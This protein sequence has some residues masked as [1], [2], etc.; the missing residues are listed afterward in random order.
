MNYIPS[1]MV[2]FVP[3]LT[4]ILTSH[5]Y[6]RGG[7]RQHLEIRI[8][9]VSVKS[10][11]AR[12]KGF[13]NGIQRKFGVDCEVL[14]IELPNTGFTI[15]VTENSCLTG[16]YYL[17]VNIDHP[18]IQKL[19]GYNPA[20]YGIELCYYLSFES[21]KKVL[22]KTKTENGLMNSTF[23]FIEV[24]SKT[25][26][27]EPETVESTNPIDY[28]DFEDLLA[29]FCPSAILK[30]EVEPVNQKVLEQKRIIKSKV[31]GDRYY[32]RD[33]EG[34]VIDVI[35]LGR[36][37]IHPSTTYYYWRRDSSIILSYMYSIPNNSCPVGTEGNSESF[38]NQ[39]RKTTDVREITHEVYIRYRPK[40]KGMRSVEDIL[41]SA[42]TD[43]FD[44]LDKS[45]D[46][47][48]EFNEDIVKFLPYT[49]LV[50]YNLLNTRISFKYDQEVSPINQVSDVPL[51]L[52]EKNVVDQIDSD[53][54]LSLLKK[55]SLDLLMN[56]IKSI[57][58][59]EISKIYMTNFKKWIDLDELE[60]NYPSDPKTLAIYEGIAEGFST[61]L[62]TLSKL[63]IRHSKGGTLAKGDQRALNYVKANG[64][65]LKSYT[66][67]EEVITDNEL[68]NINSGLY[69]INKYMI[70]IP[71]LKQLLIDKAEAHKPL[72][73]EW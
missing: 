41:K 34:E 15:Q 18:D 12:L 17:K 62:A 38:E 50:D 36:V 5:S 63:L 28:S 51:Y 11:T 29:D 37:S 42:Y 23:K 26:I 48:D 73:R 25:Q 57:D 4:S 13:K 56:H 16:D 7:T 68:I 30:S 6:L 32:F 60:S 43:V 70:H 45:P 59:E 22:L 67:T 35:Y 2:I 3:S 46:L 49:N 8:E 65:T 14:K 55:Y 21:F 39:I 1:K 58:N 71:R 33:K 24:N 66:T 72:E 52:V 40:Y 61:S 47:I 44:T 20:E 69:L 53:K 9:P 19:L 54:L 31:P 10:A 64:M 27:L